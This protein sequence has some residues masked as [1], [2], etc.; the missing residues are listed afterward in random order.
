[1]LCVLIAIQSASL[2]D[3]QLDARV[4][5]RQV[6]MRESRGVSLTVQARPD[7]GSEVRVQAPPRRGER[8][9]RNVEVRVQAEARL[10]SQST[11]HAGSATPRR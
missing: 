4:I 1:M 10:G 8:V 2:P 3:I 5:A 6:E 11:N 7:A 9:L